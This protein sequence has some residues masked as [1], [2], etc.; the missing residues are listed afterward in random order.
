M[1]DKPPQTRLAACYMVYACDELAAEAYYAL[2]LPERGLLDAMRRACWVAEDLGVPSDPATL[3]GVVRRSAEE[4]RIALTA[5]VLWW[6]APSED[7]MRLYEM[8]LVRQA[9]EA[10]ARDRHEA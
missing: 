7:G 6:F 8:D 2:S 9:E 1:A 3:A 4:V 5:G 10:R